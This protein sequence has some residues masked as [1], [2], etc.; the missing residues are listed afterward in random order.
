M[1]DVARDI[2][3]TQAQRGG[4]MQ[5]SDLAD[6][7]VVEREPA[8]GDYRGYEVVTAPSPGG[9]PILLNLLEILE[10]DDRS[11][12]PAD[13]E[14]LH[15]LVEAMRLAYAD[16][17]AYNADPDVEDVPQHGL[18]S[19]E[20]AAVRR[21]LIGPLR[22]PDVSAG[23][24]WPYER[25]GAPVG[26]ARQPTD[27][28]RREAHT[29][30]FLVIDAEGSIVSSTTT[31]EAEWGTGL[32]VP[33]RGFFLNNQ[34]TDFDLAPGGPNEAGPLKR[35]RS[36][37]VPS[38]LLRGGEPVLVLGASGGRTITTSVLQVILH[39]VDDGMGVRE[40]VAAPRV[41]GPFEQVLWDN[42]LA[43]SA[44]EGLAARGHALQEDADGISRLQA[45]A[46]E[47]GRWVGQE[48][49]RHLTRGGAVLA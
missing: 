25:S 40:A 37:M 36:S 6:Y 16:R 23:D 44:R 33:G 34:L 5:M 7:E 30:H 17:A 48:D 24:P 29:S 15:R 20:Y 39:V 46:F 13:V 28:G 11:S 38:I 12:G 10:G 35:P 32:L 49:T 2:V 41:Y 4:R 26:A 45:A 47:D 18:A 8:R 19:P 9:G 22:A 31:I 43:A 27:L 1:G 14:D 42:G 21:A 3:L